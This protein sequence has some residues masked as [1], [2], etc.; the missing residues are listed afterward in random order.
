MINILFS[1]RNLSPGS[2][3]PQV[4]YRSQSMK[5]LDKKTY[6]SF[7]RTSSSNKKE[8]QAL[9]DVIKH[10]RWTQVR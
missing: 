1:F 7:F 9:V 10:F 5:L 8:A 4:S 6:P 3:M 2:K